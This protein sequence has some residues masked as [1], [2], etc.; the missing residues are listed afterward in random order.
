MGGF[1]N[2]Q[3]FQ[4]TPPAARRPAPPS[5][6]HISANSIPGVPDEVT[7]ANALFWRN[8]KPLNAPIPN[9]FMEPNEYLFTSKM[10]DDS[11]DPSWHPVGVNGMNDRQFMDSRMNNYSLQNQDLNNASRAA[12]VYLSR[13]FN[14]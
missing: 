1:Q 3:Q 12:N 6:A 4:Y 14:P 2:N 8:G 7:L 9:G 13:F 5:P 10:R 11:M